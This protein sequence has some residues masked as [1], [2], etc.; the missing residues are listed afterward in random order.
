MKK[1]SKSG[2]TFGGNIPIENVIEETEKQPSPTTTE[3]F[4]RKH[5]IY[6]S[7]RNGRIATRKERNGPVMSK[8]F[9]V[10]KANLENQVK[11]YVKERN[12]AGIIVSILA[13]SEEYLTLQQIQ[14]TAAPIEA[15]METP[16][17][18]E[19]CGTYQLRAGIVKLKKSELAPH[20]SIIKIKKPSPCSAYR[21]LMDFINSVPFNKIMEMAENI[22]PVKRKERHPTSDTTTVYEDEAIGPTIEDNTERIEKSTDKMGLINTMV[23]DALKTHIQKLLLDI[24]VNVTFRFKVEK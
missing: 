11:Y 15:M 9:E 6:H 13:S 7:P 20:I 4:K 8:R 24:D 18:E 5:H 10:N 16:A 22:T 17:K 19:I 1:L 14:D 3:E 12:A 23:E 2:I 21:M